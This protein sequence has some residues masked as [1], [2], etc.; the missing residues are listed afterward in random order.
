V[1]VRSWSADQL[2]VTL[3]HTLTSGVHVGATVKYVR[4]AVGGA[5]EDG[6]LPASALLA[7][8]RALER[9]KAENHVDVDFGALAVVGPVRLWGVVRN[10][11]A[12]EFG[13]G[14]FMLP[15][16]VR[17]GAA[18]DAEQI[19][20]APL[21]LAIDAD[22]RAYHTATGSRRVV[23]AGAERWLFARRVGVR[24]GGRLNTTGSQGASITGG[25]SVAVRSGLFVDGHIVRSGSTEEEGWGAAM[26]VSF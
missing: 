14:D 16:Q 23:A 17:V 5:L 25:L 12:P 15:R 19:G 13:D 11:R 4:G 26:R 8:G 9:A 24:G 6:S 20:R 1:Q 2:G 10:V 22:V 3:L 7:R 21:T 18:F